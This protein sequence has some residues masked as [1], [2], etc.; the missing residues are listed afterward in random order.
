MSATEEAGRALGVQINT[1]RIRNADDVTRA[2]SGKS[3]AHVDGVIVDLGIP[4]NLT[5]ILELTNRRRLV[6]VSGPRAFVVAG[7]VIA[8]GANYPDLFR[9]AA[10]FVDLILKGANPADMPVQQPTR[11]ELIVNLKAAR[12]LGVTVPQ[13]L[14]LRA[15]EV[16]E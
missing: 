3:G 4:R 12:A 11:F 9:R 13:S 16:I 15:N 10:S 6:T 14:L 1:V 5:Q 7:G 8:Y 2:L